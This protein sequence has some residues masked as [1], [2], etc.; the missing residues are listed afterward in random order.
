MNKEISVWSALET[1]I[2]E[3][4][5][6]HIGDRHY[7]FVF[8]NQIAADSWA[9]A[10]F[11]DPE[12]EALETGRFLSWDK[13]LAMTREQAGTVRLRPADTYTRYLWACKTLEENAENPFL[14]MLVKPGMTPPSRYPAW[15]A[16]IASHLQRIEK[17]V[18]ST[19]PAGSHNAE[20]SDFLVLSERY[21]LFLEDNDLFEESH[22]PLRIP[23]ERNFIFFGAALYPDL[24]FYRRELEKSGHVEFHDLMASPSDGS[25]KLF[26]FEDF[27]TE[28]RWVCAN[29]RS[30]LDA[31][32]SAVDI[33][34]SVPALQ[35]DMKAYLSSF[36][37]EYDIS[38]IFRA[39][40][41]L[42]STPFGILLSLIAAAIDD[43][44]SLESVEALARQT[45]FA[46]KQ[47][48]LFTRLME[49]CRNFSIPRK[50]AGKRLMV[51]I[52]SRTF[53]DAQLDGKEELRE[54]HALL[55]KK[56]YAIATASS[57]Q[58]L[59]EALFDFRM[60][61]IE[62]S[63]ISEKSE[64][65]LA[66]IFDEL[67][68]L[69]RTALSLKSTNI[70]GN[71]FQLFRTFLD[72]IQYVHD[73]S[74]QSISVYP[75]YAGILNAAP[76]HFVL[77]ASQDSVATMK[78]Y[79]HLPESLQMLLPEDPNFENYCIR[80]LG[81]VNALYCFADLGL[82]GFCV[83]HPWFSAEKLQTVHIGED[84]S[85]NALSFLVREKAAWQNNQPD[86][87]QPL[88][89]NQ[90]HAAIG[91][92]TL[93]QN[94]AFLPPV[95][96]ISAK[97]E[98]RS[99]ITADNVGE[100]IAAV[101]QGEAIKISPKALGHYT[102]C[103]FS[104][105]MA[106]V[107]RLDNQMPSESLMIG[108]I[109]HESIRKIIT[110]ICSPYASL[111]KKDVAQH[112]E[113]V[114]SILHQEID[115][116]ARKSGHGAKPLLEANFKKMVSRLLKYLEFEA[117]LQ[118]EGWDIGEFEK[119]LE[120]DLGNVHILF[121]GR[122]DRLMY[123][124]GASDSTCLLIDYKKNKIPTKRQLTLDA[125]GQLEELQIPGYI[126]LLQE[127]GFHIESAF[128]YSIENV[129][130]QVVLGTETKAV[131]ADAASYSRELDA[132]H[133]ML[134][135]ASE[136]ILG[137]IILKTSP[138]TKACRDCTYGPICRANYLSEQQ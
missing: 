65:L 78:N 106:H 12:I 4:I 121:N 27:R 107:V 74:E 103:P 87:L 64:K 111:Q 33:A 36:A 85:L 116:Q 45:M 20:I 93:E 82:E 123:K 13:F 19:F 55:Q 18:R 48:E 29:I 129:K 101:R 113:L 31:G 83:P 10:I 17:L 52:W 77:E 59:R 58:S 91:I 110:A 7:Y 63:S 117:E 51:Q 89:A 109:L 35:P 46:W 95:F 96:A 125:K 40:E 6:E 108:S 90:I 84:E 75:Y 86:S 132:L 80:S 97:I 28:A 38:L 119:A 126:F 60:T 56:L 134:E 92:F 88:T 3:A 69:E 98:N 131:A 104:W 62:D 105:F 79:S 50:S 49:F 115:K 99:A 8:P 21:R 5:R 22:L 44:L 81:C 76:I 124:T 15:L 138:F 136:S 66:R 100:Y 43:S 37:C 102:T 47:A 53:D 73:T 71:P 114:I 26:R 23:A 9:Q 11:Q 2:A 137:G 130:K 94:A 118:E 34:V 24:L 72:T 25:R 127:A 54:F 68:S 122:A 61:F 67:V 128:Y 16:S 30:L 57:F 41:K 32:K 42:S 112:K 39:G 133:S 120:K 14:H 70:G 135:K 1:P